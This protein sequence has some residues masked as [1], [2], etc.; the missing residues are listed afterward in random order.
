MDSINVSKRY[1]LAIYDFATENDEVFE[2]FEVLNL[3]LEHIKNDEDFKKFLKYPV[4]DKEEKKKL[5][6]HIYSDVNKQSLKIL[7][8]LVDKDR[9]L[10]IKEIYE[11]YSKIYY[12]KHKK[13]IVTAIFPKEL[14]EAQKEKLTENLKKLKGK[15]VVIHYRIDEK[16]IG[17]GL[18]RINDE[19]IDGSIKTQLNNIKR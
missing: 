3:L 19:V 13:L 15:D 10:H 6:N 16:L 17:G 2:V 8:Y 14:T 18:I 7:D 1:A 9:L 11:E 12:E 5:I 4:I